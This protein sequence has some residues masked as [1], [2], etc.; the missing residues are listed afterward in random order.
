MLH[1]C[2]RALKG[3]DQQA[4]LSKQAKRPQSQVFRYLQGVLAT[5]LGFV[6]FGGVETGFLN[7]TGIIMNT[8]GRRFLLF[9]I[10]VS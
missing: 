4:S 1:N 5:A 8:A 7:L 9:S 6:F 10:E 2:N 3:D